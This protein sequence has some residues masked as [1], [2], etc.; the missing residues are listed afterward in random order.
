MEEELE[1]ARRGLTLRCEPS[2]EERSSSEGIVG[3]FSLVDAWGE[4]AVVASFAQVVDVGE[5][6]GEGVRS[7]GK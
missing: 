4:V 3:S 1:S 7:G 5:G 2:S 6:V